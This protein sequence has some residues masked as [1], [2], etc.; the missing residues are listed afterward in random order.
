LQAR[1]K[2]VALGAGKS[3]ASNSGLLRPSKKAVYY[4]HD[5]LWAQAVCPRDLRKVATRVATPGKE[6]TV[7]VGE[8]GGITTEKVE[9]GN[10]RT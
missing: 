8:S 10:E 3:S 2:G 4:G 5:L 9:V 1:F 7:K 6:F